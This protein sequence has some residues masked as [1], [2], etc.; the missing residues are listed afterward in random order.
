MQKEIVE[1][2]QLFKARDNKSYDVFLIG[3]VIS[4]PPT[5]KIKLDENIIL[6]NRKLIFA[7]RVTYDLKSD[8]QVILIPSINNQ[9]YVVIDKVV[10][11]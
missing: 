10:R 6:N 7:E 5:P 9:T 2:A 1:L 4:P 3:R 11:Y 8:D